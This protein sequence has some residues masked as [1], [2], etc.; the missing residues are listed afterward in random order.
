M[1]SDF[2]GVLDFFIVPEVWGGQTKQ[3]YR[4]LVNKFW[5]EDCLDAGELLPVEY[6][7][8]PLYTLLLL[9]LSSSEEQARQPTLSGSTA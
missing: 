5:I 7:H 8:V 6:H 2:T 1:Y 9:L 4:Q 3:K